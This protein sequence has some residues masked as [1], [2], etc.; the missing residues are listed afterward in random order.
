ML[1]ITGKVAVVTGGAGGLCSGVA[2][3]FVEHGIAVSINYLDGEYVENGEKHTWKAQAEKVKG[4]LEAMGGKVLVYPC[5]VTKPEEVNAWIKETEEKLGPV[6]I[7]V[8]GVGITDTKKIWKLSYEEFDRVVR[9]N[10]YSCF[11]TVKA[12]VEGMRER[13]YGRIINFASTAAHVGVPGSIGYCS[14][15][16]GLLGF[17][18]ALAKE[19]GSKGI[20]VNTICPGYINAGI[21]RDVKLEFMEPK[22]KA[23]PLQRMGTVEEIAATVEFLASDGAGFITGYFI[24]VGGGSTI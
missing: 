1:H 10:L 23:L 20:T 19:V 6:D 16:S 2:K 15:K 17:G 14:S 24:N 12:V 3:M 22:I 5:D 4:E 13:N 7:L 8:N 11:N 9:T 18:R 21:I